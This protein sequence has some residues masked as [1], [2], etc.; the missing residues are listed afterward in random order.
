MSTGLSNFFILVLGVS[1]V[2]IMLLAVVGFAVTES[3]TIRRYPLVI[4]YAALLHYVWAI[5]LLIDPRAG[6]AT[7]IAGL[8]MLLNPVV[9]ALMLFV[10]ASLSLLYVF[11]GRIGHVQT[12]LFA[13]PQQAV[14]ILS[15]WSALNAMASGHY[16]D[17]VA[18][19]VV[20]IVADQTPSVL[21]AVLHAA[22]MVMGTWQSLIRQVEPG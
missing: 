10:V 8:S 3:A 6:D 11:L 15:A 1:G 17:G 12:V 4:L 21:I 9:L 20:F 13:L 7:P 2:W 16:A 18:R 19:P 5:C 22:A 14:L